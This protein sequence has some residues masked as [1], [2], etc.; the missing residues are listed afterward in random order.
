MEHLT[1][2][3]LTAVRE[4]RWQ[5]LSGKST[6]EAVREYLALYKD[7]FSRKLREILLLREQSALDPAFRGFANVYQTA[8]WDLLQRGLDGHPILEPLTSLERE[9]E[10]AAQLDVET[11]I[12]TLPFKALLPLLFFQFPAFVILLVLPLLRDL[13]L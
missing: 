6:R 1:P 13:Q 4:I 7:E 8:L 5:L 10:R 3:L 9:I 2:P 12:S 11:H